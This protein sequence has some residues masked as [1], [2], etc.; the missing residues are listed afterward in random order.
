M[1]GEE[2]DTALLTAALAPFD[3]PPTRR[4]LS[5]YAFEFGEARRELG[6]ALGTLF[7]DG[8]GLEAHQLGV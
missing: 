2:T 8:F 5:R 3:T 7:L 4:L 6:R 1:C